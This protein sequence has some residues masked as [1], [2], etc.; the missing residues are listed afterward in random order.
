MGNCFC[1]GLI[2]AFWGTTPRLD[3]SDDSLAAFMYMDMF[4]FDRLL[5]RSE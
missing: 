4:D 3:V 1:M 5:G 2:L